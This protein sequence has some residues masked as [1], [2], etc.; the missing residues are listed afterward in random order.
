M[1]GGI[2]ALRGFDYQATVILDRLFA[3]FDAHGPD[4]RVR[5]EGAD[6]L[7]L[8]WTDSDGSLRQRFEQIKK[9]HEDCAANATPTAWTL[10]D[11]ARD[12]VPGALRNLDGNA[13]E[14]V[15]ILGDE[16]DTEVARLI[17]AGLAA[18]SHVPTAYWRLVHLLARDEAMKAFQKSTVR[19]QLMRWPLPAI[20]STTPS[21]A[22]IQL[23]EGFRQR[24]IELGANAD[25]A[26]KHEAAAQRFHANLPD[27]LRRIRIES[28]FGSEHEIA[29]RVQKRLESD[30]RL[31]PSVVE[32]TLFRN[33][34]GFINDIAKQ[35]GRH[36]NKEE[37]ELELCTVWPTMMPIRELPHLDEMHIP[38]A[39]LSSRFTTNWT[40]RALEVIG[41][42]GSG[43]TML[44]AEA[45]KQSLA[46]TPKRH[47]IYAEAR[48]DTGF[49]DVMA[50]AAFH[51]RRIG[52][53]SLFSIAVECDAANDTVLEKLART[54]S[55]LPQG[56]L[57][58]IDLVE[59]TC[60]D[61]FASDLGTFLRFLTPGACRIGVLGQE[62]AFRMINHL[63]RDQLEIGSMD[64][65]GFNVDEF[66]A[67]VLKHHPHPDYALLHDVFS[68]VTAGRSSGLYVR[69]AQSL[70]AAPSLEAMRD[71]AQRPADEI[72][73]Y[74]ERQRYA[75]VSINARP[76]AE[77]LVCFALPFE[78]TEAE[79]VFTDANVGAAICELI[80]LGLLRQTGDGSYEMHE[81]IRAGL[82][83]IISHSSRQKSH[84]ELA[85]H[86][87]KRG[88]VTA[89][90]F[91]LNRAGLREE[92]HQCAREAFL[93]GERWPGLASLV[94]AHKLVTP[95]EV[96]GVFAT[97]AKIGNAY[98]LS[99]ILSQLGEPIDAKE[100]LAI[101]RAQPH[102]FLT[103]FHWA[104]ALVDAYLSLSP[105]RLSELIQFSLDIVC[106]PGQREAGLSAILISARK[107]CCPITPNVLNIFTNASHDVKQSLL[108]FL[109]TDLRRESLGPAFDF[110]TTD[111]SNFL[112]RHQGRTQEYTLT[113]Q[114]RDHIVE[115]LAALPTVSDHEMLVSHSPLLGPLTSLIWRN[116][117]ILRTHSLDILQAE[118][119]EPSVQ[120]A[121]I[122]VL[123]L[124]AEPRLCTLCETLA[125]NKENSIHGFAALAPTLVPT[126]VNLDRYETTVLDPKR[127]IGS[128][129]VALTILASVGADLG[130]L[131]ERVRGA[132]YDSQESKQ[133]DFVFLRNSA[134]APFAAAIPLFESELWSA[135]EGKANIFCATL[136]QLGRL[137][138]PAAT[139]MLLKALSHPDR[140]VRMTATLSLGSKR[141]TTALS[142]LKECFRSEEYLEFRVQLATAIIASGAQ[143]VA[144]L[145]TETPVP[146]ALSL[147]RCVLAARTS[148][149]TYAPQLVALA[150]D[151]QANW[152]LR[153]AAINAAG[154]LPFEAALSQMLPIFRERSTLRIDDHQSL[155]VHNM[156]S[157]LLLTESES[158]LLRFTNSRTRFVELVGGILGDA[159][160][161]IMDLRGLP[162]EAEA[163]SWLFDRLSMYG[164]PK[165]PSA[166]D[167]VT[168]ELHIPLLQSAILRTLRRA[169]R[170]DLIKAELAKAD[171][172]WIATKCIIELCRGELPSTELVQQI[173]ELVSTSLVE[174]DPR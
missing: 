140:S 78:R 20:L 148:D 61:A 44:A 5:P 114:N 3:H 1:S 97:P 112:Q 136:A 165:N 73:E 57:L 33:L 28:L 95:L 94:A 162:P 87:D 86:Y 110:I 122:R 76:A 132:G 37:F 141:T 79:E 89:K 36:F 173:K 131:Y 155:Y 27:V 64:V 98:L 161:G 75:R 30:Y 29:L 106:E 9:P 71:L 139:S 42:S 113:L 45:G 128:R 109:L 144:V 59:G 142:K 12:L 96:V 7:D 16:V 108:S 133:W 38:R 137:S 152:Q 6:D 145:G 166:P 103:D 10:A 26:T 84:K 129:M 171:H 77:K 169:G 8:E 143:S 135:K 154:Y 127:D 72:L 35:P 66:I 18:P 102:R 52:L 125:Q 67:L 49:R 88:D 4:A 159:K 115:F 99:E 118:G 69:L 172:V 17:E 82:E 119:V 50:G 43:K 174:S 104:S 80:D 126:L 54:M 168:N 105:S 83:G 92:A 156:L 116:R 63:D 91:H 124:L 134:Q 41:V 170:C 60:S 31:K 163:A 90:V 25:V 68:K 58:L 65:R 14:Q 120:K 70:A 19:N 121:A 24:V 93:R 62:S 81:T 2:I 51:L 56:V 111:E 147:W 160:C 22:L 130:A 39:D 11:A 158:L 21:V 149:V 85:E 74:A 157:W 138:A 100:I 55:V 47:V 13:H 150:T 46:V 151:T 146:E 117:H 23:S 32:A 153:R 164:W 15:W 34:R 48:H 123:A 167:A 101:L 40:G 107:R 53:R